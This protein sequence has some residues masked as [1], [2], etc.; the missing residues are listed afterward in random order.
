MKTMI[1][2]T[3]LFVLLVLLVLPMARGIVDRNVYYKRN[4][5]ERALSIFDPEFQTSN[6]ELYGISPDEYMQYIIPQ[7]FIVGFDET[8]VS[9]TTNVKQ[10]IH[11]ILTTGGFV[12]A[13]ALWY[14][15]TTT[16]VGVTIAGVDDALYNALKLD[17]T[18]VLIEPVGGIAL[19]LSNINILVFRSSPQF[20][21]K[22]LH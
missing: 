11:T 1:K 20:L 6:E 9:D 16:F 2:A 7:Q 3:P 4:D 13:T 14:Y 22:I 15:Q 8:I 10:Y 5:V 12:N 19:Y 18:V 21:R 17:P